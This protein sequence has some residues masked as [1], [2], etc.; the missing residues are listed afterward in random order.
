MFNRRH[1]DSGRAPMSG[2]RVGA[3]E[4]WP[5]GGERPGLRTLRGIAEVYGTTLDRLVDEH[6]LA[7]LPE[8]DRL[9]IKWAFLGHICGHL[10][11]ISAT[12]ALR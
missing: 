1:D 10:L 9:I 7:H 11:G 2:T 4:R 12:L 3:Y 6:D 5:D 8:P